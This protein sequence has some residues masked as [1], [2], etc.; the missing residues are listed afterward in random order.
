M[1][2]SGGSVE[3]KKEP[4]GTSALPGMLMQTGT[5]VFPGR[6]AAA[7]LRNP[8]AERALEDSR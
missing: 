3:A 8:K 7:S 5:S 2:K 4:T 6:K 1:L